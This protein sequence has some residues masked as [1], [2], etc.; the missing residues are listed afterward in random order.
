M[1]QCPQAQSVSRKCKWPRLAQRSDVSLSQYRPRHSRITED[2]VHR[3]HMPLTCMTLGEEHNNHNHFKTTTHPR[4]TKF[5][6][7]VISQGREDCQIWGFWVTPLCFPRRLDR[8]VT[9]YQILGGRGPKCVRQCAGTSTR[10][11]QGQYLGIIPGQ[12]EGAIGHRIASLDTL[13]LIWGTL[14]T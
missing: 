8:E 10:T 4:F 14:W 11:G 9:T 5:T 12:K 13:N 3:T 6:F 7:C 1:R 2:S